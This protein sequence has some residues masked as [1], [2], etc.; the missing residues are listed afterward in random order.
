MYQMEWDCLCL[1]ADLQFDQDPEVIPAPWDDA[2]KYFAAHLAFL[3]LQNHNYARSMLDLF[4]K[5]LG[6]YGKA[7]RPSRG[8]NP[9]GRP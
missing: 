2:V 7:A 3:E 6:I 9:Y 5:N 1:P 8:I 4:E